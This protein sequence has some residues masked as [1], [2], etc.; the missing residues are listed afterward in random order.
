MQGS[1]TYL[2]VPVVQ[3]L[4][5]LVKLNPYCEGVLVVAE[6]AQGLELKRVSTLGDH[7]GLRQRHGDFPCGKINI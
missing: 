2:D 4:G 3:S 1:V 5:E 6:G 7:F